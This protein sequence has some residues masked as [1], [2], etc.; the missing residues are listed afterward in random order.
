MSPT[1]FKEILYERM[2]LIRKVEELLLRGFSE[3]VFAGTVHTCVG[4]EASAVGV[5]AALEE[6]DAVFSNHRGHGHMLALGLPPDKFIFELAGRDGGQCR[7]LG[8]SQHIAAPEIGF[9]GS[10]GI[11]GGAVPIAVGYALGFKKA[12]KNNKVVAF[13]GDGASSQGVVHEAMNMAAVWELPIIF[14][15]ENNMYAMSS[16]AKKFVAGSL[17]DRARAYGMEA[18]EVDGN[19][20][21]AVLSC[22]QTC[23]NAVGPS[24]IECL[25]YRFCGHSKSDLCRY[26]T[27]EELREWKKKD[28]IEVYGGE[29]ELERRAVIE[30]GVKTVLSALALD[31]GVSDGR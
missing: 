17:T 6:G 3:G 27:K 2:Y 11:T 1:V 20:V 22:T 26:R 10:N 19:D 5:C 13:F 28:P 8:G 25:T 15:C 24:F 14:V 18:Y 4:Q 12:G 9:M 30:G 7:G 16:P 31:L 29:I 21:E 23:R